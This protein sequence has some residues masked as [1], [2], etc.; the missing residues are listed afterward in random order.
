MKPIRGMRGTLEAEGEDKM[1]IEEHT[2]LRV[3]GPMQIV[4]RVIFACPFCRAPTA[5]VHELK[6][7]ALAW[8]VCGEAL[9][10]AE[11]PVCESAEM[12]VRKWNEAKR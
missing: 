9:C 6:R 3:V 8:V 12:A 7:A 11:G 4:E 1:Q 10:S 5:Y 2:A